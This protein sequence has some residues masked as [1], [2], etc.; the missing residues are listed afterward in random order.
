MA[1]TSKTYA[2]INK[3]D[4]R[5]LQEV[6]KY[7]V[8][9]REEK[10][11]EIGCGRGFVV[12]ELQNV[13][14]DVYGI[15]LN[16][17]SIE[18]GVTHNLRV[19]NAER[20]EFDDATFDKLYSFHVIEHISN[21]KK[22]LEEMDRVLRPGG[23]ILLVY[24]AEPIRGLFSIPAA[25]IL[26]KNPFRTRDVHLHKLNPR[27]IQELISGTKLEHKESKFSFFSSPQ[28]FTVLQKRLGL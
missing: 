18:H 14:P 21:I 11:L 1:Y 2:L 6:L 7:L 4:K 8:P 17:N 24:P 19:M 15:D 13:T 10:I 9:R 25:I 28:H 5:H 26:F 3:K 23:R 27:R 12:R 22:A 16:P 20:L